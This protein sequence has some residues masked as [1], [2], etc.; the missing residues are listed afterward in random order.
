MIVELV[1]RD[2][3][4]FAEARLV[5][6]PGFTVLTGETGAG[7]SLV[8]GAIQLLLGARADAG[9]VRPGADEAIID[10]RFVDD[11]GTELVLSRVV[12]TDG[13]SRAY[14][15]GRPVTVAELADHGNGMV[16]LHGQHA[17]QQLLRAESQR[18]ALDRFAGV[19]LGPLREARAEIAAVDRALAELGGDERTRAREVDLLRYQLTE[20]DDAGLD[21]PAED[22]RLDEEEDVLADAVAH[23]DS[24]LAA[25]EA[26]VGDDGVVD[27]LRSAIALVAGRTPFSA[28]EPR[29]RSAAEEVA[30]AAHELR[31][32]AEAIA[33]DPERL[34]AIRERRQLLADLRRKYGE[35]LAEIIDER[36]RIRARLRDIERHDERAAELAQQRARAARREQAEASVVAKARRAAAPALAGGVRERLRTLAMPHA[37][38]E[39]AVGGPDPA[40]EVTFLLAANPGGVPQPVAKVASGGELSRT[41]LALRLELTAGPPSLVFDE[42]DA[43]IGGEAAWAVGAALGALARRHQILVVTHLPQVAAFADTQLRVS[44]SSAASSTDARVEALDEEGRLEELARMLSGQPDSDVGRDH[45]VEI[46][47]RAASVK[48]RS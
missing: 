10:G 37:E 24:G 32:G 40:D 46:L 29:L 14:V 15:N 13:R 22:D 1:V 35:T 3:G 11:D 8:V 47:Q 28:L 23:R 44:K 21:D 18:R 25:A 27:R 12:P 41:T 4:V 34:T 33:D 36:E 45:A 26:L 43:G 6:G 7:K 5:L 38:V 39:V 30:E 9:V 31:D 16:E 48:E 17:H 2:L 42:V 20:L 19:D